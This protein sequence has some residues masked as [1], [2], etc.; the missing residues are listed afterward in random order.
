M[1]SG[2]DFP[3]FCKNLTDWTWKQKIFLRGQENKR[4]PQEKFSRNHGWLKGPV[5]S[6]RVN[7]FGK[8][9][10]NVLPLIWRTGQNG[11]F[12]EKMSLKIMLRSL[13]LRDKF[14]KYLFVFSLTF[15]ISVKWKHR[16]LK[17]HCIFSFKVLNK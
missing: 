15:G 5:T 12:N 7:I 16:K 3:N 13:Y 17:V 14:N 6:E 1:V 9:F 10:G 4:I 11:S 8:E 2:S